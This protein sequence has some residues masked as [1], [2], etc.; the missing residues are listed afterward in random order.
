VVLNSFLDKLGTQEQQLVALKKDFGPQHAEVLKCQAM[1]EDLHNKIKTRVEGIMLGLNA[2]MLSLSN[3]LDNL[4]VEVEKATTNDVAKA[5]ETRPYF[6]AKR[7]LEELQRFRQILDMKIA[8]EKIDVELPKTMMVQVVDRAVPALRPMSPNLPRALA[9]IVL[10]IL[11]DIAGLLLL[12]GR[13]WTDSKP[14]PA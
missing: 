8:N 2:R 11:L 7:N 12:Q 1:V 5:N 9:L 14:R 13:A 10:G 4:D 6:E 3:S